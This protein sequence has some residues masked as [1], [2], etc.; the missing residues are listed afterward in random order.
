MVYK[1]LVV[2]L[3]SFI[4]SLDDVLNFM[5]VCKLWQDVA[6]EN[7]SF[8]KH[9][10]LVEASSRGYLVVVQRL[11]K[12]KNLNPAQSDNKALK[13]ALKNKRKPIVSRLLDDRRVN[14]DISTYD[15][16]KKKRSPKPVSNVNIFINPKREE[17]KILYLSRRNREDC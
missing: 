6:L 2:L 7:A 1:D 4:S 10:L 15:Q 13:V 17:T 5:R 16:L 12:D 9:T 8:P 14:L 11:L 3:F